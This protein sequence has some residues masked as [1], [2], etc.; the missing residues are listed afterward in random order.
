MDRVITIKPKNIRI[1]SGTTALPL[2]Y[3]ILCDQP[4]TPDSIR[5]LS[6]VPRIG[7]RCPYVS[8]LVCK[9]INFEPV[10]ATTWRASADFSTREVSGDATVETEENPSRRRP[11]ILYDYETVPVVVEKAFAHDADIFQELPIQN[12]AGDPYD[13]PPQTTRQ[14]LKLSVKWWV[15]NFSDGYCEE[16]RESI[17]AAAVAID[18]RNYDKKTCKIVELTPRPF[19][20]PKGQ[21]FIEMTAIILHDSEGFDFRPLERGFNAIFNGKK[22]PVYIDKNGK[23]TGDATADGAK[24]ITEPV[25]LDAN[26]G[27]LTTNAADMINAEP[28]FGEFRF[29]KLADWSSLKIPSIT[30][31]KR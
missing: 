5:Q 3:L 30:A 22:L 17:N 14:L 10:D 12:S 23:Y 11:E 29:L 24:R 1:D 27:V 31:V 20:T 6:G 18:G 25:L 13:N 15:R 26:G 8:T 4:Q 19:Y 28:V 2:D 7:S 16:F 9:N 21:K